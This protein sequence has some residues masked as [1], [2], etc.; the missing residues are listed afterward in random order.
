MDSGFN[1]WFA[2]KKDDSGGSDGNEW[3]NYDLFYVVAQ[4]KGFGGE[5]RGDDDGG[6]WGGKDRKTD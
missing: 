2:C 3:E 4:F 1:I 6:V 5:G